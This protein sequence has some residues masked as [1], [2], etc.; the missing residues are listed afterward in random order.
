M[1]ALLKQM[2]D[3]LQQIEADGK[4]RH[5]EVIQRLDRIESRLETVYEQVAKNS[6]AGHEIAA[7]VQDH[8]TDIRLIKKLLTNQ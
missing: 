4:D 6:E 8:E 1:E 2:L 7:T 3:K 5:F